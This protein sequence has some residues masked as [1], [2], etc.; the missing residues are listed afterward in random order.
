MTF[1]CACHMHL[2]ICIYMYYMYINNTLFL[3]TVFLVQ[4]VYLSIEVSSEN[5]FPLQHPK[6][7]LK[8]YDELKVRGKK[9]S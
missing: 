5:H 9:V 8:I 7:S 1:L 2:Y 3:I 6:E 4:K